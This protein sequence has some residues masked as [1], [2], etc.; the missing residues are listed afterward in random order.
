MRDQRLVV[1]IDGGELQGLLANPREL[2]LALASQ[3]KQSLGSWCCF[4]VYGQSQRGRRWPSE[5]RGS[6]DPR[7][8]WR[9]P[10]VL[11]AGA[12]SYSGMTFWRSIPDIDWAYARGNGVACDIQI[13]VESHL[14]LLGVL[15]ELAEIGWAGP[16]GQWSISQA[17]RVWNGFGPRSLALAVEEQEVR[18]CRSEPCASGELAYVDVCSGGFYSITAQPAV[19]HVRVWPVRISFQLEGIP[20]DTLPFQRFV[21]KIAPRTEPCF[22]PLGTPSMSAARLSSSLPLKT[23]A[24][25]VEADQRDESEEWVVRIIARSPFLSNQKL[26]AEMG[27]DAH[28]LG[29]QMEEN[30]FLVCDLRS[31]HPVHQMRNYVLTGLDFASTSDVLIVRPL[32]DWID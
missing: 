12:G 6:F 2:R 8:R 26:V 14:Q 10:K 22:R 27:V 29:L 28:N 32:A 21:E 7:R 9:V 5:V 17:E 20:F 11:V 13:E 18:L 16:G 15:Q 24:T 30:E 3:A 23:V 1:M 25:V 31:W 4:P 19:D